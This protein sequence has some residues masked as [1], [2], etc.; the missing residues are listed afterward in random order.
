MLI[1]AGFQNVIP[2]LQKG[3]DV[4]C[5]KKRGQKKQGSARFPMNS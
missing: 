4:R 5:E 2:A 1:A 3:S